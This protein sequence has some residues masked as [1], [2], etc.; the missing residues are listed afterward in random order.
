MAFLLVQNYRGGY[1]LTGLGVA[2]TLVIE[3]SFYAVLPFFAWLLRP[4]AGDVR[5]PARARRQVTG[6][7]VIYLTGPVSRFLASEVFGPPNPEGG[8]WF[9]L[10]QLSQWLPAYLDWFALGM[11]L[12]VGSAWLRGGGQLPRLLWVVLDRPWLCWVIAAELYWV[13]LRLNLPPDVFARVS[14]TQSVAL[15]L[16][17]GAIALCLL[18]PV[19]FG[20]RRGVLPGML[21]S[22]VM[23][24]LGSVSYGIYLWHTIV[25]HVVTDSVGDG[26]LPTNL[27]LWLTLVV[28]ATTLVSFASFRMMERPLMTWVGRGS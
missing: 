7:V 1:A 2:W 26:T 27:W 19:V 28:A 5:L 17:F 15:S 12:A 22:P 13:A 14:T 4:R 8:A 23:I 10:A 6:L 20:P 16:L 21:Q 25:L 9:P 24:F 11:L 18:A 3:M